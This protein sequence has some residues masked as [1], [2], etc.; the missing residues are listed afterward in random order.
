MHGPCPPTVCLRQRVESAFLTSSQ[1]LLLPLVLGP[2]LENPWKQVIVP[3]G[4]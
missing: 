1:V 3:L 4:R 2:H